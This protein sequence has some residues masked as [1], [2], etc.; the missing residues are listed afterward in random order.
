MTVLRLFW[1]IIVLF[2]AVLGL[3][4]T[5]FSWW[6]ILFCTCLQI[7]KT[8]WGC[9]QYLYTCVHS[10]ILSLVIPLCEFCSTTIWQ[11]N[12]FSY[13]E[14]SPDYSTIDRT[15]CAIS[16]WSLLNT[17]LNLNISADQVN[18]LHVNVEARCPCATESRMHWI[19]DMVK[20]S[21]E[22]EE[23]FVDVL[24]AQ[25]WCSLFIV[26]CNRFG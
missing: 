11:S 12:D 17:F 7:I 1:T 6:M 15:L 25:G 20:V 26:L 8:F 3:I 5:V 10:F 13:L 22:S 23:L 21:K 16:R 2:K 14:S 24:T 19:Q 9:V 18:F 4:R